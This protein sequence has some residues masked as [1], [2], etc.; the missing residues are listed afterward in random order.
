[1]NLIHSAQ[2][3]GRMPIGEA[4]LYYL[5]TTA[6]YDGTAYGCLFCRANKER[7]VV[8]GLEN[9]IPG[10]RG[11]VA[12]REK[13]K[14]IDGKQGSEADIFLPGY[15]FF[16]APGSMNVRNLYDLP[17]VSNNLIRV[18]CDGEGNWQLMGD[19]KRFAQWLFRYS[20]LLCFSSAYQ[21]GDRI[22]IISGPLK[23][24]E[25][26]IIRVNKRARRGQISLEFAH[27]TVT[28]WLGFELLDP[29]DV[30]LCAHEEAL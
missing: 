4:M 7:T 13:H 8:R 12:S 23:D 30:P 25:G 11:I 14:I 5:E 22:R 24:V 16:E 20:G 21:E 6:N 15:V 10:V 1:M 17:A 19:D 28:T 2:S 3:V 26:K 27:R 29:V 9:V 18:L